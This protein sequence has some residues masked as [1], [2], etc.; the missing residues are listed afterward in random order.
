VQLD[1][2]GPGKPGDNAFIESLNATVRRE[3]LSRHWFVSL[4]NAR[5]TLEGFREDYNN[6][7]LHRSLANQPPAA[8]RAGGCF[9][10]DR[11]RLENLHPEWPKSRGT[12]LESKRVASQAGRLARVCGR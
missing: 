10:P 8:F 2:S 4:E 5:P 1:F 7:R 9:V 12:T 11:N 6:T 3:C